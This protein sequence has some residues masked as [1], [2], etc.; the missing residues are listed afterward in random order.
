MKYA[1]DA[2]GSVLFF[3]FWVVGAVLAKGAWST[4]AAI[5]FPPWGWYLIAEKAM[6]LAGWIS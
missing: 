5:L 6:T 1:I 2:M 4:A 3:V